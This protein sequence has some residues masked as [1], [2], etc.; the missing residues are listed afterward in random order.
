[1]NFEDPSSLSLGGNLLLADPSL[2]DSNFRRVVLL[3]NHHTVTSGAEGFVLNRPLGK[4]VSELSLLNEVPEL[5]GVQVYSGGPVG[6]EHL[7]FA[8]LHWREDKGRLEFT[9]RISAKEAVSRLAEGFEVR[10]FVGHAGWAAGQL[11]DELQEQAWIPFLPDRRVLKLK[12]EAM[13]TGT[14]ELMGPWH[15]L[16]ARTPEDPSL[17]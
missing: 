6:T 15:Q 16:L 13:W 11:E 2:G 3:L 10:A 7:V 12:P 4:V 1:M 9:T 14:L 5:G 8:S 17:N